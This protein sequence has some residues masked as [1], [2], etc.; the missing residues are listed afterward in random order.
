VVVVVEEKAAALE[1]APQ[2]GTVAAK[3]EA[4]VA[5]AVVATVAAEAGLAGSTVV[6]EMEEEERPAEAGRAEALM[7]AM[8]VATAR[9][10]AQKAAVAAV[11]QV[12][13]MVGA[14]EAAAAAATVAVEVAAEVEMEGKGMSCAR[15][16]R[17]RPPGSAATAL[18]TSC[19]G[20][21]AC[22]SALTRCCRAFPAGSCRSQPQ[23]C[24]S[25]TP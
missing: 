24:E 21:S 23:R 8:M 9:V 14:E 4:A 5:V 10:E 16:P 1:Q 12:K 15:D 25:Q 13:E 3:V 2:E 17:R 20:M 19:H 7:A 22:S 6:A 11:M 18:S